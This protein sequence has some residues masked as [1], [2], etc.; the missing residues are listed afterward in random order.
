MAELEA[1]KQLA[2]VFLQRQV[3]YGLTLAAGPNGVVSV[4]YDRGADPRAD[5]LTYRT[6]F[7][8]IAQDGAVTEPAEVWVDPKATPGM[9]RLAERVCDCLGVSNAT[10]EV[11]VKLWCGGVTLVTRLEL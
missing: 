5:D 1:V 3:P 11:R 7:A 8:L 9:D 10:A 2:Q 4:Y 6:T